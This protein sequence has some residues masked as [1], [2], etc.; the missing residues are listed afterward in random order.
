M[1]TLVM[2]SLIQGAQNLKSQN[3]ASKL[4]LLV[5]PVTS[6]VTM[7]DSS[8]QAKVIGYSIVN[9]KIAGNYFYE[10]VKLSVLE[11]PCS[12]VL[13]G[14]DIL[15]QHESLGLHLGASKPTLSICV[16]ST[17][18]IPPPS[19]F[20]N[21]TRDIKPITTN[22]GSIAQQITESEA[23]TIN[24]FT[25]FDA[26]PLPQIHEKIREI[27]TNNVFSSID[28]REAYHHIPLNDSDEAY[29]AF[30]AAGQLWQFTRMPFNVMNEVA[31]FQRSIDEF[32]AQEE[33]SKAYAYLD[34]ITV[35]GKTQKEH[36]H[37]LAK[38]LAAAK[39][40]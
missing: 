3:L 7:T 8:L 9:L 36:D 16:L 6:V 10:N 28:L 31:C 17:L 27:A 14:L 25:Q 23:T 12:D 32:I 15:Q 18:S 13:I 21:R 20:A 38:F 35:C 29:T 4:Q 2:L 40:I 22:Q 33:L 24:L 11:K 37:N 30:E 1:N 26:F 34:N 39:K 19:P 5:S